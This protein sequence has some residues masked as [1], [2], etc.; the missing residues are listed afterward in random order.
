LRLRGDRFVCADADPA[1]LHRLVGAAPA[2]PIDRAALAAAA[3]RIDGDPLWRERAE[4]AYA[5]KARNAIAVE[6]LRHR[7]ARGDRSIALVYGAA[8]AADFQARVEALGFVTESKQWR[9][10][11]TFSTPPAS[12]TTS[13]GSSQYPRS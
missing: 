3:C 11:M 12:A 10:S 2:V 1:E 4:H 7:L 9:T 8:H 6:A 5:I 13:S